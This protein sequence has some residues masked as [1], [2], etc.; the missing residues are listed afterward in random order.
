[1]NGAGLLALFYFFLLPQC[2][3]GHC[4]TSGVSQ[5]WRGERRRKVNLTSTPGQET[6]ASCTDLGFSSLS[7]LLNSCVASW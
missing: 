5:D 1:M 7:L 2:S 6:R 4:L 3:S